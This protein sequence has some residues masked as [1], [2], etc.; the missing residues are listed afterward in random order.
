MALLSFFFP[1]LIEGGKKKIQT[2]IVNLKS[3]YPEH[4]KEDMPIEITTEIFEIIDS[5][6]HMES[7]YDRKLRY[8][9]VYYSLERSP[10]VE[11]HR[12]NFNRKDTAYL[13]NMIHDDLL[14]LI[15][16]G[17]QNLSIIQRKRIYKRYVEG[18]S[19]QVIA[20][21]ENCTKQSVFKSISKALD[22]L[23]IILEKNGYDV[24]D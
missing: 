22:K 18:K 9:K 6:E 20:K 14:K 2:I 7:A 15:I 24:T 5:Y 21:E 1:P 16:E 13:D 8:H 23:R 17:I 11:I 12:E 3:L 4:Y 10:Y 19:L